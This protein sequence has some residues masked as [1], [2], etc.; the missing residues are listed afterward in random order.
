MP[1][2]YTG[3][4]RPNRV[5]GVPIYPADQSIYHWLNKSAFAVPNNF[6][7]GNLGRYIARGP[8]EAEAA[9]ALS[10]RIPIQERYIVDF[11][12]EAFNVFNHPN[13]ANPVANISSGAFG[14][15]TNILNTGPT[16][17]GGTRKIEFMLRVEF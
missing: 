9:A 7:F 5:E 1:F 13:F 17:T 2:G 11:R 10:K 8:G 16:G 14:R 12:A 3:N 15:I 6:T 4:Q